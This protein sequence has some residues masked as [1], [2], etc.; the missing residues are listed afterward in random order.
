LQGWGMKATALL[1]GWGMK[2]TALRLNL[3]SIVGI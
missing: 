3:S 1:Q 2:A